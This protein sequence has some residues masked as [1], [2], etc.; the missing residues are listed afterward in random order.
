MSRSSKARDI[1]SLINRGAARLEQL[2]E[3]I[4]A[5]RVQKLAGTTGRWRVN[6]VND[7]WVLLDESGL[8]DFEDISLGSVAFLLGMY[9][10]LKERPETVIKR[11]Y[12][13]LFSCE[14]I[15]NAG[16]SAP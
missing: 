1:D 14:E 16:T 6:R 9:A 2:P 5:E 8:V 13:D 12:D 7:T 15:G 3:A 4:L 10:D 11:Y